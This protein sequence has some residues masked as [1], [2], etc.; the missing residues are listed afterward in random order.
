MGVN[1]PPVEVQNNR[2]AGHP[3]VV[4]MEERVSSFAEVRNVTLMKP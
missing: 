3:R 4:V 2:Q 1:S